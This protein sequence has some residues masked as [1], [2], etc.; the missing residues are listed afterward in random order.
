MW[1][2][3]GCSQHR[4]RPLLVSAVPGFLTTA[5]ATWQAMDGNPQVLKV[6]TLHPSLS[7]SVAAWYPHRGCSCSPSPGE[8]QTAR[9]QR[10]KDLGPQTRSGCCP[11]RKAWHCRDNGLEPLMPAPFT[12]C[13]LRSS[14]TF[15][16]GRGS[17]LC[18]NDPLPRLAPRSWCPMGPTQGVQESWGLREE[19]GGGRDTQA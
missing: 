9:L 12:R 18:R 4:G 7:L 14:S 17:S 11:C 6:C 13:Q 10:D 1:A 2:G 8:A 19:A 3:P 16:W 15:L 5:G